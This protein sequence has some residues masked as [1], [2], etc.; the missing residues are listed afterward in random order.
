MNSHTVIYVLKGNAKQ[1]FVVIK[2]AGSEGFEW[3]AFRTSDDAMKNNL[4]GR[5]SMILWLPED[6][7]VNSYGISS[8]DVRKLKYNRQELTVFSP[9]SRSARELR[10]DNAAN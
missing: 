8:D 7:L 6:V 9:A 2:K 3:V 1:N 4:S 10:K 5:L